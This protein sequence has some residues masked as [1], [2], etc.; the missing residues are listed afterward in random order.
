MLG[1]QA[2]YF[3]EAVMSEDEL[4]A[5]REQ[6]RKDIVKELKTATDPQEV[7]DLVS[8]FATVNKLLFDSLSEEQRKVQVGT[9]TDMT[10]KVDEIAQ[11]ILG[12]ALSDLKVSQEDINK[13]MIASVLGAA[14]AMQKASDDMGAHVATFGEYVAQLV[15]R[16]IRITVDGGA[17]GE[18]MA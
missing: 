18:V 12:T 8:E 6:Q 16:G 14:G 15:T 1:D 9:F 2:K 7:M 3:K 11:G 17:G 4:R 13:Q 5:A 10:A